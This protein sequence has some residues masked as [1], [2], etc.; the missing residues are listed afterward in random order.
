MPPKKKKLT[1]IIKLQITAGQANPA[2]P[3]GPALGQHGVNI[4]EFCKAYNAATESQR[5]TVVPVEISVFED[6]SFTFALKT[7]PAARLLLK[8]AGVEKGSG[9]PH[10]TKVAKVTM[11]QV[12]EIAQ[13]KMVDLNAN[14]IDQAAKI[15]AGTARSMGIT[16][17]G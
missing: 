15:I 2:P 7:P 13:T 10:K 9:E 14:D 12:R 8:A 17:E 4:M 5:G 11:D 1:A 3:V 16:V 6:R